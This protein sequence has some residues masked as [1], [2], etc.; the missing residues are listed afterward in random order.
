MH[1]KSPIL[2]K[3]TKLTDMCLVFEHG[4]HRIWL[5]KTTLRKKVSFECFFFYFL[6]TKMQ[7]NSRITHSIEKQ[8]NI[9]KKKVFREFSA[10]YAGNCLKCMQKN[11]YG[12]KNIMIMSVLQHLSYGN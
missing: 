11:L 4:S 3:E 2:G 12:E 8:N 10:C 1:Q 6:H 9:T 5:Y 7:K